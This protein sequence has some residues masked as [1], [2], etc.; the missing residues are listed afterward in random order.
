MLKYIHQ[1]VYV[2]V[3]APLWPLNTLG[4]LCCLLDLTLALRKFNTETTNVAEAFFNHISSRLRFCYSKN[5][6]LL[7][8]P[9]KENEQRTAN[10]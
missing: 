3:V 10:N 1:N 5:I 8:M 4:C 2:G 7:E 9:L 6:L